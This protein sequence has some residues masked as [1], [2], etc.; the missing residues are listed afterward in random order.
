MEATKVRKIGNVS[1]GSIKIGEILELSNS[2]VESFTVKLYAVSKGIVVFEGVGGIQKVTPYDVI[3][4]ICGCFENGCELEELLEE[5]KLVEP[6]PGDLFAGIVISINY[7][8]VLANRYSH[9]Q[10]E[11]YRSWESQL[12]AEERGTRHFCDEP[13]SSGRRFSGRKK[14]NPNLI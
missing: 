12:E 6:Y 10:E 13:V 8:P 11:L 1:D 3:R 9:N 5:G 7:I 2:K 4:L 14:P